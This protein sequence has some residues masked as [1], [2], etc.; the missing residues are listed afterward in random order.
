MLQQL[1]FN[2]DI[3]CLTWFFVHYHYDVIESIRGIVFLDNGKIFFFN[4]L[5]YMNR[6]KRKNKCILVGGGS[7]ERQSVCYI[8]DIIIFPVGFSVVLSPF[9]YHNALQKAQMRYRLFA[10]IFHNYW[11]LEIRAILLTFVTLY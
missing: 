2:D 10:I 9:Q 4:I 5:F 11:L 7:Q 1:S 6:R 3:I 8:Y